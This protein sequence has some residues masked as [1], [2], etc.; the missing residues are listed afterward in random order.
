MVHNI[1]RIKREIRKERTEAREDLREAHTP[2]QK[3]KARKQIKN[4]NAA[5]GALNRL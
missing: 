5:L 3:R 1:P 2:K 4:Y